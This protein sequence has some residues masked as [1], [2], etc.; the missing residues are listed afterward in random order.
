MSFRDMST[1]LRS[2]P[3]AIIAGVFLILAGAFSI[4]S[5]N[6]L[7]K[8]V[9]FGFLPLIVLVL[10]PRRASEMASIVMIFLAG[11]FT[12]WAVGGVIGQSTLIFTIVWM[13]FRPE[14]REDPYALFSLLIVWVLIGLLASALIIAA[15]WFVYRV[16]PDLVALILQFSLATIMLPCVLLLR[17]WV[18][19]FY[20]NG[21]EWGR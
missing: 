12:D 4:V 18:T 6:V 11:L 14:M 8:S 17:R 15:G 13:I 10:W 21:D 16:K 3:A 1:P 9:S 2:L 5:V 20:G 19:R 7:G